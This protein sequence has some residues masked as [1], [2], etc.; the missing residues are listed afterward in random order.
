MQCNDNNI[1]SSGD[2]DTKS[3][4]DTTCFDDLPHLNGGCGGRNGS[5]P[6]KLS[7]SMEEECRLLQQMG[8]T[9]CS[10]VL[11]LTD[12]EI[13]EYEKLSGRATRQHGRTN[14]L[15]K[16]AVPALSYS[17]TAGSALSCS[18]FGS[19]GSISDVDS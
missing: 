18:S 5:T 12:E 15:I 8:W 2:S 3:I 14:G 7:S 16:G 19:S 10:D 1:E 6:S 4:P 13:R 9:D 17:P 11:P